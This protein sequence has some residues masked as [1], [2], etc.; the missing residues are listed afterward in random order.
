MSE[1]SEVETIWTRNHA[2]LCHLSIESRAFGGIP[3]FLFMGRA[4]KSNVV[5]GDFGDDRLA[6]WVK[7]CRNEHGFHRKM[8][9]SV[10]PPMLKCL[11]ETH[12]GCFPSHL[13]GLELGLE[14]MDIPLISTRS[15]TC[16]IQKAQ[17]V[18]GIWQDYRIQHLTHQADPKIIRETLEHGISRLYS[19]WNGT[20]IS[21]NFQGLQQNNLRKQTKT[22]LPGHSMHWLDKITETTKHLIYVSTFH[23][24][25][26]H[27]HASWKHGHPFDLSWLNFLRL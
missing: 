20:R 23:C 24:P 15:L 9:R 27:W 16:Q 18:A 26:R 11:F 1:H 19:S 14:R 5:Q 22:W 3:R 17:I 4:W 21:G 6:T 7:P 10:S 13:P 8:G 2:K 25:Q 12:G